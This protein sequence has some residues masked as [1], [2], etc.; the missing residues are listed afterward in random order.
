MKKPASD[1]KR[2]Y[3][4]IKRCKTKFGI[5][6][7]TCFIPDL[8]KLLEYWSKFIEQNISNQNYVKYKD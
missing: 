8:L 7:K 1:T 6:Q 4:A 3:D 5:Y 2:A